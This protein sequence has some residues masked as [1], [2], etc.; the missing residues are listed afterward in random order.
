MSVN[1]V[2]SKVAK[3]IYLIRILDS[4]TRYF[5]GIWEIPEGV[6]YN[7]YVLATLDGAVVFDT[8]KHT[9]RD[10]YLEALSRVV[11]LKSIKYVVTHH[12]E[13]DHSGV[14]AELAK[15][16][17]ATLIG[18][19]LAAR[20]AKSFYNYD[21]PFRVVGDN[22]EL[23]VGGYTI[24]FI[25]T[26]WLH[27]PETMVSYVKEAGALLTCDAFG[28]YGVYRE[29]FYDELSEEARAKYKWLMLK[30]FANIIGFYRG[31]VE[32]NIAK[33][34]SM[35]VKPEY[36]LPAHGL[37][38]RGD[39]I[40]EA[41]E[42]YLKWSRGEHSKGKAVVVYTSMYGFV[43]KAVAMLVEKLEKAGYKV[44]AYKFNDREH[45]LVS[46]VLADAYDSE[47][48]VLA[49][50]SYDAGL[51]PLMKHIAGLLAKKVPLESK[52]ISIFA[53]YGWGAVAGRELRE[54]LV[55]GGA[56]NVFVAEAGVGELKKALGD[57]AGFLKLQ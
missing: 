11:D 47:V 18:H 12:M 43:E 15:L 8:A 23:T 41:R 42:L 10:A 53:L 50:S 6:V 40:S 49:T 16:S 17:G 14:S 52:V 45:S 24:R 4:A 46:N 57:L 1:Y 55:Q 26:P 22:S 21:G 44:V 27:W 35:N 37:A 34:E 33:I 54:I 19:P 39:S 13:P 36:V 20:M 51:F 25:H 2:V 31:W 38:L 7:S 3:D 29:V 9:Y 32:K 5:E 48:L 56:K 28:S 30:Y